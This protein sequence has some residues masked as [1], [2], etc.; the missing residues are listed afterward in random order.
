MP[1]IAWASG[2]L[3]L[4][5]YPRFSRSRNWSAKQWCSRMRAPD[6]GAV[7]TD[8]DARG[9]QDLRRADARKLEELGRLDAPEG[10]DHLAGR[11][12]LD[13]GRT[14]ADPNADR[15]VALEEQRGDRR[16]DR[17]RQVGALRH[18]VQERG[19]RAHALPC[20]MFAIA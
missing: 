5:L 3:S 7:E 15:L 1:L 2:L 14:R 18:R 17:D 8:V 6:V 4:R 20:L 12:V 9:A 11:S 16:V 19:S 10:E 13:G